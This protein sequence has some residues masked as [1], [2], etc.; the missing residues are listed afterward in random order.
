MVARRCSDQL[1]RLDGPFRGTGDRLGRWFRWLLQ[2]PPEW[3]FRAWRVVGA[4][5]WVGGPKS[6]GVPAVRVL[7]ER[8]QR[9]Q[10]EVGA[11][12]PV[13]AVGSAQERGDYLT[14]FLGHS[15]TLAR[16]V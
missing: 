14:R 16:Q 12:V 5:H 1:Y 7:A 9:A 8:I 11:D 13:I 4:N 10:R 2:L 6:F 3:S 15:V